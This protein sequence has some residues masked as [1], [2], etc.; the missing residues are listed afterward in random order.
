MPAGIFPSTETPSSEV[1]AE[2]P[3]YHSVGFGVE[4]CV[5]VQCRGGLAEMTGPNFRG[6]RTLNIGQEI[7]TGL[8]TRPRAAA[9]GTERRR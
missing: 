3:G 7:E 6:G 4:R 5:C 8:A 9:V 1:I 2:I